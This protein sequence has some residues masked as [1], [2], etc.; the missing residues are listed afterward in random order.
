MARFINKL[1]IVTGSS[2]GIGAEIAKAFIDEGATVIGVARTASEFKGDNYLPINFD[3]GS[4]SV[5]QIDELVQKIVQLLM[6]IE[7]LIKNACM[8]RLAPAHHFS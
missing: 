6:K 4:A 3:F 8:I 5:A 2:R 1:A 7:I